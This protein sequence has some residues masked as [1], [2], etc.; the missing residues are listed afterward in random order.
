MDW[1]VF[2]GL[3]HCQPGKEQLYQIVL[4]LGGLATIA[5]ILA[6]VRPLYRRLTNPPPRHA[7]VATALLEEGKNRAQVGQVKRAMELYDLS[8]RL[9]P[10]AGH[11]YYLRGLLHER[12][13][14]LPRAI[15]DWRRSLDRLPANNPAEQ[16]LNQYAAQPCDESARYQWV[17]A[18][19]A[20]GLV[21][22][23]ALLGIL[24]WA[25]G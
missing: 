4:F 19:C 2:E 17:Y 11:I 14:N 25:Q 3:L 22:I 13:E 6:A 24:G 5:T 23:G 16:K 18:Y 8:I 9:N 1:S 7:G 10:D 20:C 21:L 12:D 15:A